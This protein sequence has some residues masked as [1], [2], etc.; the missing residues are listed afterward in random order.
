LHCKLLSRGAG[1]LEDYEILEVILMAFIPHRDVKP[2]AKALMARF[3][4]R[5]GIFSGPGADLIKVDSIGETIAAYLKGVTEMQSRAAREEIRQRPAILS[6]SALIDYVRID[7]QHEKREPF[8]VLFL[9]RKNQ[10]I[11]DGVMGHGTVDH[12]PVYP[13]E[14]A[15]RALELQAASLILVH[16]HPSGD[17]TPPRPDIDMTREIIDVLDP[18]DIAVH[19][20]LI[21]G[22]SG[23]TRLRTDGLI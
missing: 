1:A 8:P 10:H 19:D 16:N 20:H 15:L 18:F 7:L 4:S 12:A 22:T 11:P 21:A 3:G 23:V 14:I 13:R 5:S 6:R 2:I 17:T 9:A